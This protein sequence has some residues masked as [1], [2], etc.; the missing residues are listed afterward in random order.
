MVRQAW[1]VA[2]KRNQLGCGGYA[3]DWE[4]DSYGFRPGRSAHHSIKTARAHVAAGP[5]FCALCRRRHIY[6]C[7]RRA[8][9][10]GRNV[11]RFMNQHLKLTL[12]REKSRV[13][14]SWV[15]DY[16]KPP[17]SL[18]KTRLKALAL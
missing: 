1:R 12:N 10:G 11:E 17:C 18:P 13:A 7:S 9:E 5:S 16:A 4:V 6:V 2:R 14:R 3:G 15:C 8:G